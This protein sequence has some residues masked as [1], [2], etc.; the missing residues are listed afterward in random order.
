MDAGPDALRTG[1]VAD[2]APLGAIPAGDGDFGPIS[3]EL[4]LVDPELARR[5]REL[6]PEP[7]ER[8]RAPRFHPAA[9]A[10]APAAVREQPA[11]QEPTTQRRRWPLTLA[12]AV[13]IFAV[14]A[15]SGTFLGNDNNGSESAGSPLEVRLAG[16]STQPAKPK[17]T[18]PK[19]TK[20]PGQSA[21]R[22]GV[23]R[24]VLRPPTVVPRST[25]AARASSPQPQRRRHARVAWAS[26][27]LGVSATV[28]KTGVALTWQRPADSRRVVVLRKRE[29]RGRRVVVYQGRATIYRDT[30]ARACAVYRYTILNYDRRGHRSTGVPTSISTRCADA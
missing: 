23:E 17:P 20:P 24:P 1:T 9:P 8:P 2:E 4:A 30:S 3:P 16:P 7:S 13:V 10:P 11:A 25:G 28:D 12:L 15:V 29:G 6:L 5:A 14:G 19:P 27:V 22:T 26:N 18:K 21:K